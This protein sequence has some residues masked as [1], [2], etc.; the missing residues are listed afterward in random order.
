[1]ETHS[2]KLH[3]VLWKESAPWFSSL[4]RISLLTL[5]PS[6]P[7]VLQQVSHKRYTR[8]WLFSCPHFR[9]TISNANGKRKYYPTPGCCN[10]PTGTG[11]FYW[12]CKRVGA[13]YCA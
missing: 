2:S 9:Y 4:V 12:A 3:D 7:T 5:S 13:R 8:S 6:N 11:R 1:M 10:A